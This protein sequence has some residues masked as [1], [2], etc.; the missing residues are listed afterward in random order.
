M[1]VTIVAGLAAFAW[2]RATSSPVN[3]LQDAGSVAYVRPVGPVRLVAAMEPAEAAQ[4]FPLAGRDPASVPDSRIQ[5]DIAVKL[6]EMGL[7]VE[8]LDITVEERLV[9]LEGR[10]EDALL[11][12]AI[13]VTVRSVEGVREVVN[14]IE[15]VETQ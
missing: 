8:P 14:R 10:V 2:L 3:R 1:T 15:V 11:R 7:P 9:T 13:E 4:W 6:E 5:V 12:D